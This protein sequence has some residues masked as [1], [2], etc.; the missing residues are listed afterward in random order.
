MARR[1]RNFVLAAAVCAAGLVAVA[2]VAF[3]SSSA[4]SLD[5]HTLG[6][7]L[8]LESNGHL[9]AL[10]N[11]VSR[12]TPAV[13]AAAAVVLAAVAYRQGRRAVALAV[14]AAIGA[15][16]LSAEVLKRVLAEPDRA[17]M[18]GFH[19]VSAAAHS[20]PSGHTTAAMITL[21]C[22]LLVVRGGARPLVA[23]GGGAAVLLVSCSMLV[24][25]AHYPSDVLGG[26]LL[27]GCWMSLTLAVVRHT[28]SRPAPARL[29]VARAAAVPAA[30]LAALAAVAALEPLGVPIDG[31]LLAAT[32]T[33]ALVAA[34][35]TSGVIAAA[36]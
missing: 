12:W 14:P 4:R 11:A 30:A 25:G 8:A 34:A 24:V 7:F 31:S 17:A 6:S 27:A 32:A 9:F 22:A 23:L 33:L 28:Q 19:H 13:V 16:V 10:A 29:G 35:L 3:T 2:L 21:L 18:I 36:P 20:W 5:A 15:S 26:L 1:S